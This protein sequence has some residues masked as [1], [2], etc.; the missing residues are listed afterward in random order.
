MLI[1][2]AAALISVLPGTLLPVTIR[3]G[4]STG[5]RE[6]PATE[7]RGS[8]VH[9]R[10]TVRGNHF[11]WTVLWHFVVI[12]IV[13]MRQHSEASPAQRLAYHRRSGGDS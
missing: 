3:E 10:H 9:Y 12:V 4:A 2:V 7:V 11:I 1:S 8:T 6:L 5:A 13:F